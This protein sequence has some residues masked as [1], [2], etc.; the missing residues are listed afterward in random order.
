MIYNTCMTVCIGLIS[1][2][3][4]YGI[5]D[6]KLTHTNGSMTSGFQ[7]SEN[8]KIIKLSDNSFAMFAGH[9]VNANE[10]LNMAQSKISKNDSVYDVAEHVK[11]SYAERF[12]RAINEEILGKVNLDIDSFNQQ[13][14]T[15]NETFVM[16]TLQTINNP[17]TNLGIEIIVAGKIGDT[18]KLL[19]II[20]PGTIIDETPLGYSSIGSGSSHASLSLMDSEHTSATSEDEAI[21]ALLKAKRRAEYDPNVGDL[22]CLFVIDA[23]VQEVD[24]ATCDEL[25]AQYDKSMTEIKKISKTTSKGMKDKIK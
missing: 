7:V 15:L 2:K 18:P 3:K 6:K 5:A 17:A 8:K 21:Y 4:I 12:R 24:V 11:A 9:V 14:S 20:H 10:V 23:E 19:K 16:N 25:M 22:S 1:G 13:Q